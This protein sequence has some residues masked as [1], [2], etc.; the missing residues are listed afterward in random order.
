MS[1]Y[2]EIGGDCVF[3]QI[4]RIR[5]M[6][7]RGKKLDKQDAEWYRKNRH[8]VVLKNQYTQEEDAT[9]RAWLPGRKEP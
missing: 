2:Y 7:A 6:L 1:Y 9:I 5:D 4:V 8:L 3:A